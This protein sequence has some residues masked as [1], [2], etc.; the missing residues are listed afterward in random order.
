[1]HARKLPRI[2]E[3]SFD[4]DYGNGATASTSKVTK[5]YRDRRSVSPSERGTNKLRKK[6]EIIPGYLFQIDKL[7]ANKSRR[8]IDS[9]TMTFKLCEQKLKSCKKKERTRKTCYL[10]FQ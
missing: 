4:R 2:S 8:D 1:M 6:L 10:W 5:N 9:E 3:P 7:M